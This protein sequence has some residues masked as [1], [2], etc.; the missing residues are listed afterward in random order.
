M[1]ITIELSHEQA[2]LIADMI[3]KAR[4]L[5]EEAMRAALAFLEAVDEA[6]KDAA[7]NANAD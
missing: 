6:E 3:P 1:N 2:R 4:L 7:E 5:R